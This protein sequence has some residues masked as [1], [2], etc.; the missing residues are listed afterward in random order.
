MLVV[1]LFAAVHAHHEAV[2]AADFVDPLRN[3][4]AVGVEAH[5]KAAKLAIVENLADV[6]PEHGLAAVNGEKPRPQPP[7][8]VDDLQE[9]HGGVVSIPTAVPVVPV[10]VSAL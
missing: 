7:Q 3:L 10:A 9:L 8:L 4:E 6:L 2:D 5:V 1:V